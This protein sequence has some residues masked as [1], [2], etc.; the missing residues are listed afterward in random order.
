M[1]PF[2]FL[3]ERGLDPVEAYRETYD[4]IMRNIEFRTWYHG[5]TLGDNNEEEHVLY[6]VKWV[7]RHG[8][9][10]AGLPAM[11]GRALDQA[12]HGLVFGECA[13]SLSAWLLSR[14]GW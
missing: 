1:R 7:A 11:L 4:G 3:L 6:A 9:G 10:A 13:V 2:Y 12:Q 8:P 5:A 14:S